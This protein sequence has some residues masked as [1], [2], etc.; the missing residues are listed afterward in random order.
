MAD[1]VWTERRR[2][3]IKMLSIRFWNEVFGFIHCDSILMTNK[4]MV[5]SLASNFGDNVLLI[6]G[7]NGK[8]LVEERACNCA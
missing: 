8:H 6:C 5:A 4:I 3:V 7:D 1:Q 2:C